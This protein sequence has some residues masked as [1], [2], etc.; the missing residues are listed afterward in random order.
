MWRWIAVLSILSVVGLFYAYEVYAP[1]APDVS[2]FS[3]QF[4][5]VGSLRDAPDERQS[6][7]GNWWLSSGGYF[8]TRD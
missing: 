5:T 8:L 3:D 6:M 1:V 7:S 2:G 4:D